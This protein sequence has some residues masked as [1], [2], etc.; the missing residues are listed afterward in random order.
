MYQQP[1]TYRHLSHTRKRTTT[2]CQVLLRR[3]DEAEDQYWEPGT[4]HLRGDDFPGKNR[5]IPPPE[6]RTEIANHNAHDFH[7]K[8]IY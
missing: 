2:R 6:R 1:K 5:R 7:R 3:A 8:N 4:E